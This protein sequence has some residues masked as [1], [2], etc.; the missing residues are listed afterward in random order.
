MRE[1]VTLLSR[2]LAGGKWPPTWLI[3]G[4]E[5]AGKWALA[6]EL[7]TAIL[8]LKPKPW[9]CGACAACRRSKSFG[10]S[11]L[12]LLFP[13][14]TGGGTG[15]ARTKFQADFTAEFLE[16]KKDEP[17]ISFSEHR[18]RYIPAERVTDLLRWAHLLPGEGARK[19]ALV[20]EPE[21]IVRTVTDKLLK[22]TEEPP[23]ETSLILVSHKPDSL[24]QTIRS[25]S[26][27]VH[28]PRMG[29]RGL[30]S[31]L[32]DCGHPKAKAKVAASSARGLI[33]PALARL[34]ELSTDDP[35]AESLSLLSGLLKTTSAAL[36]EV[37]VWQW[38]AERQ[39]AADALDVWAVF[40][41]DLACGGVADPLLDKNTADLGKSLAHFR[42]PERAM[43]AVHE[44]RQTQ[45][46][47]ATNVHIGAALVALS[48][49]L[50]R[51]GGGKPLH[52]RFWPDPQ[53]V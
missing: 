28:V 42:D 14:P 22:L 46:A 38:K 40:I 52:P 24:P 37:Q 19:V 33:G 32:V 29:P 51:M 41:R 43:L 21:M 36:S 18:N 6:M 5:G 20:Y 50:A 7:A 11:D 4:P 34:A 25:R 45:A 30:E 49:R 35:Q 16:C 2:T 8:C 26:R 53:R 12:F 31:Y 15:K 48:C 23:G 3:G 17:L 1:P 27:Q 39:R 10:H 47:L 44:I 9:A 13:Y